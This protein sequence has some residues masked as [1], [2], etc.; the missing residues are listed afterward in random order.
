[1]ALIWTCNIPKIIVKNFNFQNHLI[2]HK[3]Y[4]TL[5]P[6]SHNHKSN[7]PKSSINKVS[8]VDVH[9]HAFTFP[10]LS[11]VPEILK[12][13]IINQSLVSSLNYLTQQYIYNSCINDPHLRLDC[14]QAHNI[15]LD[16]PLPGPQLMI[17][18][19]PIPYYKTG[20][21]LPNPSTDDR[22]TLEPTT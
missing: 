8:K 2:T 17:G 5:L 15:R 6:K 11:K 22:L 14:P 1:M 12:S 13:T 4:K 18:L 9:N 21:P 19:L 3:S 16:F 20:L 10:R 7:I